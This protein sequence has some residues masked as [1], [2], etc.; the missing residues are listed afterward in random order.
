MNCASC[1]HFLSRGAPD[2]TA[3]PKPSAARVGICR[4]YP[5]KVFNQ[6][7]CEV[8]GVTVT[9]VFPEV[10]REQQCGE[11]LADMNVALSEQANR[12]AEVKQ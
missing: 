5:P 7:W 12:Y 8:S 2:A 6:T 11:F 1:T 10:H 9:S 3:E 4:R